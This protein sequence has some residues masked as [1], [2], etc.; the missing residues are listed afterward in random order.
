[1]ILT[2]TALGPRRQ[3]PLGAIAAELDGLEDEREALHALDR[4]V[5]NE[6]ETRFRIGGILC[7]MNDRNWRGGFRDLLE[8]LERR[9]G[10]RKSTAYAAMSLYRV[11]RGSGLDW[12]RLKAVGLTKLVYLC[13]RVAS[14]RM[15]EGE[16]SKHLETAHLMTARELA[17]ALRPPPPPPINGERL[18]LR[19]ARAVDWMRIYGPRQVLAW[20]RQAFPRFT[21]AEILAALAPPPPSQA[22][23]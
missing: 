12:A 11:L 10:M 19:A 3:A 16:F 5:G 1:M 17:E 13:A 22:R 7:A 4:L 2:A 6:I 9:Y 23:C 8:L 21:A 18:Q 15:T 14:G 20:F